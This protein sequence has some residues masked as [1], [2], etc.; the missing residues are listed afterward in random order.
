MNVLSVAYRGYSHS[1]DVPPNEVGIKKDAD[2]LAK[3]LKNPVG[4]E[5]HVNQQLIFAHGRS[6]GG[7]VA[8]Y[9]T[10]EN[11]GLFRGLIVENS[12]TS[13]SAMVDRLY[14]WL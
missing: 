3:F 2:A 14:W 8:I 6:L 12:F 11:P 4:I 10:G 5:E 9:M 13:I 1:D 7:A